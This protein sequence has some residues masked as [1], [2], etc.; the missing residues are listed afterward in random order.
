MSSQQ[1]GVWTVADNRLQ[2]REV[3]TGLEDNLFVEITSGLADQDTIALAA[4]EQLQKF[5]N[6]QKVR[7]RK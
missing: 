5:S 3:V 2:F 4:P 6:G 7:V 1:R